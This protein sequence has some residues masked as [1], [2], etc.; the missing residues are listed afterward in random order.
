MSELQ[1]HPQ[2]SSLSTQGLDPRVE[3]LIN[4]IVETK[5][6]DADKQFAEQ[7]NVWK[8]QEAEMLEREMVHQEKVI[9]LWVFL[10]VFECL[11]PEIKI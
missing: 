4:R 8:H 9:C 11:W 7:N 2:Y 6:E 10:T 1:I 5:L 3:A